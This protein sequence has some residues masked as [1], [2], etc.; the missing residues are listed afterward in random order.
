MKGLAEEKINYIHS[1]QHYDGNCTKPTF[2]E[3][4]EK[5]HL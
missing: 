3:L 2:Y 4:S 1:D 5:L